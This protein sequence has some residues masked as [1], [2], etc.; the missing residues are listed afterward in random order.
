MPDLILKHSGYGHYTQ[1]AAR[2]GL[3]CIFW[4]WLSTFNSVPSF[5][6]RPR[7]FG[8]KPAQIWS[9][10]PGQVLAKH[11][12]SRSKLVCKNHWAQFWQNATGMLPV[13]PLSD[14][15][16]FF[17]RQPGS[18][19]AKLAQIRFGS[20]W[21]HQVLAKR[22]WSKSKPVCKNHWA[23]FWP[24][25][26][27]VWIRC[28]SFPACLLLASS[29]PRVLPLCYW[30]CWGKP[31][32]RHQV[33]RWPIPLSGSAA[34]HCRVPASL[35]GPCSVHLVHLG[36]RSYTETTHKH[37]HNHRQS[38][39]VENRLEGVDLTPSILYT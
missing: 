28:K 24:A 22:I 20:G 14:S 29:T 9:W 17:H 6:R 10:W 33:A 7:S 4:I 34:R 18:Y 8:V 5:Q 36:C 30:P 23:C 13:S 2:I 12:W 25:S 31:H 15:V 27:P 37:T 39:I 11:I 26:Q 32:P 1:H 16:A 21:L 35:C 19:C 38:S 3:D